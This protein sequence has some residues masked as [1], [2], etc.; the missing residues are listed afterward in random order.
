[1]YQIL[2]QNGVVKTKCGVKDL[3]KTIKI[4]TRLFKTNKKNLNETVKTIKYYYPIIENKTYYLNHRQKKIQNQPI[5]FENQRK[6]SPEP[7]IHKYIDHFQLGYER[8]CDQ[9]NVSKPTVIKK[10]ILELRKLSAFPNDVFREEY[11]PNVNIFGILQE[12]TVDGKRVRRDAYKRALMK[13]KN[14]VFDDEFAE[15]K[16]QIKI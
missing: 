4:I 10:N 5:S 1:M 16:I 2:L 15:K 8:L 12:T 3:K 14:Q 6:S 13:I 11:L 7:P 9:M